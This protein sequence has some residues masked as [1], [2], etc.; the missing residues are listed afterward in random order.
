MLRRAQHERKILNF[1]TSAPLALS[2]STSL[3]TGLVEG[4]DGVFFSSVRERR[5]LCRY[6]STNS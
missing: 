2:P 6:V 3:R 4:V 1:L 5:A